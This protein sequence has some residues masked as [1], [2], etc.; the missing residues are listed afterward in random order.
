[1]D[2]IAPKLVRGGWQYYGH[3]VSLDESPVTHVRPTESDPESI[4]V[5]RFR[6]GGFREPTNRDCFFPNAYFYFT[7]TQL[8]RK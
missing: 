7:E 3:S 4:Q 1:M 5:I 6:L 8:T 2:C